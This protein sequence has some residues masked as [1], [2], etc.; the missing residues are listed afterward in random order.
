MMHLNKRFGNSTAPVRVGYYVGMRANG[1]VKKERDSLRAQVKCLDEY[2]KGRRQRGLNW[3]VSERLIEASPPGRRRGVER[4]EAAHPARETLLDLAEEGR[5]DVVM[6]AHVAVIASDL[7]DFFGLVNELLERDVPVVS[8]REKIDLIS[9][10]GTLQYE[11]LRRLCYYQLELEAERKSGRGQGG[12]R[13]AAFRKR[14]RWG[15]RDRS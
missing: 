7:Q 6:V 10:E 1:R 8:V 3:I 12:R 9:T 11:L 15:F 13:G 4:G 14:P 5:I 2:L